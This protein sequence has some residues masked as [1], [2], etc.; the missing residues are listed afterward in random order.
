MVQL[1]SLMQIM[2]LTQSINTSWANNN[3]GKMQ[4]EIIFQ[5][6]NIRD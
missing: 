3:A 1:F 5:L 4:L 2:L 6:E